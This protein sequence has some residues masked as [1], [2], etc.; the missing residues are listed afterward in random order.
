MELADTIL[1]G[2]PYPISGLI[3]A[4]SNPVLT[5]PNSNKM[6]KAIKSLEFSAA[7]D[8]RMTPTA[9][10]CDLFLPAATFLERTELCDYYGT[11]HAIPFI[12]LRQKILQAGEAKSDLEFWFALA[13]RMGY[14]EFFP[15]DSIEEG[16]DYALSSTNMTIEKLKEHPGGI[17]YGEVRIDHYKEKGFPTPSGKVE[18]FSNFLKELGH[19]PI[20]GHRESPESPVTNQALAQEYPLILTTGARTVEFLHSMY[21]EIKRLRKKRPEA[22]IEIHPDTAKS[23]S[24]EDGEEVI[25]E[26]RSGA[27]PIKVS[28]TEDILPGVVNV[29][30]GWEDSNINM[31]TEDTSVDPVTG[32]PLLKSL[33]CRIRKK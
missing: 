30:H 24:I 26:N 8:L 5:W 17:P 9:Q 32:Y 19:D 6:V 31:L 11:L 2:D 27:I 28:V 18:L 15:W 29:P 12:V 16:L 1:T 25:L 33:L 10:L 3:I 7:M 20:P 4:G 22:T 13:K 21:R 23:L 14:E